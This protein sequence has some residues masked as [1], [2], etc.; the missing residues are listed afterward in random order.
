VGKGARGALIGLL[1]LAAVGGI[2][3]HNLV[4]DG[5]HPFELGSPGCTV[6][7]GG[8]E[9]GLDLTQMANAA[10]I[11]AVGISRKVPARAVVIA[12]ATALQESKLENLPHG[13]RDSLGLFQQRPSQGWG[14]A[15]QV[16]D[17]RY[18]ARK[19]YAALLKVKGWQTMRVTEAAQR[20][21]RSAYPNAYEKWADEA[22]V[23]ADA[24]LGKVSAAVVCTL[25]EP[26]STDVQAKRDGQAAVTA[27]A[28]SMA[29]D[30]GDDVTVRTDPQLGAVRVA[31]ASGALGWA[32]AHWM[33]S[34]AADRGVARVTYAG[35]EW[36][37]KSGKW[38]QVAFN[39]ASQVVASVL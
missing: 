11:T 21:Q 8:L 25:P 2:A 4:S 12:L 17:P 13:D 28:E 18:A 27:L 20:V 38:E 31:A 7:S 30:Y 19:F 22:Q 26:G 9:V 35:H 32:Y 16:R 3:L 39:D 23:M 36:S 37:A 33:V 6:S 24:L 15:E 14:T 5:K 1:V 10:T 34:Q 29:L